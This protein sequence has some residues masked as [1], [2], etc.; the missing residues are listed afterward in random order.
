MS[1]IS[2]L[3]YLD[4]R[5]AEKPAIE[6]ITKAM[7]HRGPDGFSV[8]AQGPVAFGHNLFRTTPESTFDKQPLSLERRRLAITCDARIDNRDELIRLLSIQKPV[9]EI[10]DSEIILY[11]YAAWGKSCPE[12]LV[13]DFSFAIWDERE[14]AL[15]CARDRFGVKPFCYCLLP[16]RFFAF[17]SQI[18]GLLE[19]PIPQRLNEC[20]IAELFEATLEGF[21]KSA[22]FYKDILKLEPACTMTVSARGVETGRYWSLDPSRQ[23]NLGSD[24]EYVEAFRERFTESVR[25]RMRSTGPVGLMLS[26]G[27]DSSSI[28]G[29]AS[30][31]A[32]ETGKELHTFSGIA[33]KNCPEEAF[34][35]AVLERIPAHSHLVR[36]DEASSYADDF[37]RAILEAAEPVEPTRNHLPRI[38]YRVAQ[39]AGVRVVMDGVDGDMATS[40]GFPIPYL[41]RA[42]Q[43]CAALSMSREVASRHGMS[44]WSVLRCWGLR[45]VAPRFITNLWDKLHRRQYLDTRLLAR[46]YA[47]QIALAPL[48][49]R[50]RTEWLDMKCDLRHQQADFVSCGV[51]PFSYEHY[52]ITAASMGVEP[53]HPF[54]DHR[55]VEF[56]LAVPSAQK[57]WNGYRK[58][59]I[60][61]AA[62]PRLPKQVRWRTE[63]PT[64][65]PAFTLTLLAS[66]PEL[67][68]EA[69]S[70]LESIRPYANIAELKKIWRM[71]GQGDNTEDFYCQLSATYLVLWLRIN[72][73][74]GK[75]DIVHY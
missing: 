6:G 31:I 44:T 40:H 73:L 58:G 74:T 47:R 35:R 71:D 34:I 26:G 56:C 7:R 55:L 69:F 37:E 59:L 57:V 4:G 23:I 68:E 14:R 72:R 64:A 61:R 20:L 12:R 42:G 24:D 5:N 18:K 9:A 10:P 2:G 66:K 46:G 39:Q 53:R 13:G 33:S 70:H 60:R 29:A 30:R 75:G 50:L 15:F 27:I 62:D 11:A 8:W 25:C 51:L 32:D 43:W 28:A 52:D 17:A 41:L 38:L 67:L 16:G 3:F 22:T 36:S 54:S 65:A 48:L 1:G 45:P 63:K 21:D 19:L 49:S